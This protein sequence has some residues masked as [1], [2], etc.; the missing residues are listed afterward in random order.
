MLKGVKEAVDSQP[1]IE[2]DLQP[3]VARVASSTPLRE[4]LDVVVTSRSRLAAVVDDGRLVGFISV[5][6]VAGGLDT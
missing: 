6:E 3:F 4:A 5:D 2:L 1:K